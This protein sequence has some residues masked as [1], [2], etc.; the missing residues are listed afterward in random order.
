LWEQYLQKAIAAQYDILPESERKN[1]W[2][3]L[4]TGWQPA[5]DCQSAT[6]EATTPL[7][8]RRLPTGAQD[9]ILPHQK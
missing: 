7:Q 5:A 6:S 1:L 2:G 3:R 4:A 8:Q 9:D